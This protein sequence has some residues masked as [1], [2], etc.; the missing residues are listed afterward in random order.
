MKVILQ[1]NG[2]LRIEAQSGL[3]AYAL[4]KWGEDNF[5]REGKDP[6]PKIL[7]VPN[8]LTAEWLED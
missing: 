4:S 8:P 7:I 1:N 3:E 2:T 6:Q 5:Y